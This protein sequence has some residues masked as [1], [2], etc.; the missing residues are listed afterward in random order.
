MEN[1]EIEED[2]KKFNIDL[3]KRLRAQLIE[4]MNISFVTM[5]DALKWKTNSFTA[6]C[7]RYR[8][9]VMLLE[10]YNRVKL[11]CTDPVPNS[12]KHSFP[13]DKD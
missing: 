8:A 11:V 2:A 6:R 12:L 13:S 10:E 9:T 1:K 4:E 5:S 7:V 3:G